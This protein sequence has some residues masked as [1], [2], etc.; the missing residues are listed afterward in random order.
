MALYKP[1]WRD[2]KTGQYRTSSTWWYEF[3]FCNQR[4]RES[5]NT[6]R[7]TL[8]AEAERNRRLE[9]EK[10][11]VGSASNLQTWRARL[12]SDLIAQYLQDY[13]LTHREAS[14]R[15]VKSHLKVVSRI[16]GNVPLM[17]LTETRMRSYIKQRLA[18]GVSGRTVNMELGELSRVIGK[19]WS[20]LWPNL[21]KLEE[22]KD[23]GKA[24]TAEEENR[25]L[26]AAWASKSPLIGP[27]VSIALMTGMR[28]GEILGLQ[29]AQ[30]DLQHMILTVGKAKTKA[31]SG[32]MIPINQDLATIFENHANW[33]QDQIG[34]IK[35]GHFLFPFRRKGSIYDPSTRVVD[36]TAAWDLARIRANVHCRFHDLRHCAATKLAEAG[37]A[38][39]TMLA[40]LGHTSRAMFERYSH[41]RLTAKRNAVDALSLRQP[42]AAE[43]EH[44]RI[45]RRDAEAKNSNRL[46]D[47]ETTQAGTSP[48][49]VRLPQGNPEC[50]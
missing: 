3:R 50:A 1:K 32:R 34:G 27:I 18:T 8:A 28:S 15:Y 23:I 30:V 48:C 10:T 33:Y 41:I 25:L 21:R 16:V 26:T 13:G 38:E 22:R 43:I 7:K 37:V 44:V 29:W 17:E 47:P 45:L 40:I 35:A 5:T 36:I 19:K 6:T 31:G 2:P 14:L 9:M 12:V 49:W 4:I 24:L 20:E 42:S 46:K 39:S 11:I